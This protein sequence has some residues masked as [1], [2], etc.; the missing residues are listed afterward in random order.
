ML[1]GDLPAR[2][3]RLVKEWSAQ[4]QQELLK[5]WN[6]NEFVTF[7]LLCH[8]ERS[9]AISKVARHFWGI[10]VTLGIASGLSPLAMTE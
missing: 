9:E 8:C 5:M 3:Q 6:S 7:H 2:A 10:Q 1:E 4:Y